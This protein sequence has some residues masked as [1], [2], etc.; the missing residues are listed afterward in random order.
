MMEFP[1]FPCS[2]EIIKKQAKKFILPEPLFRLHEVVTGE[3]H[4]TDQSLRFMCN[5]R[6]TPPAPKNGKT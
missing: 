4:S 5:A 3:C 2:A 1:T 6:K